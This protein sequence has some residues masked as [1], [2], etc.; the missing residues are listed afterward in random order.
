MS[1]GRYWVTRARRALLYPAPASRYPSPVMR[2]SA[3]EQDGPE[4]LPPLGD[5]SVFDSAEYTEP[6]KRLPLTV[7]EY[8][9][10]ALG[11]RG[12]IADDVQYAAVQR[13][14]RTYEQWVAYKARRNTAVKRLV[15][16]PPLPRG[17]YLWGPVGRGKSFLMDSFYLTVPLV[18][19]RRVHFHHFMRDVHREMETLKGRE[20]PLD[21]V[22]WRI[23]KRYRL[24]CFDEFH[25]NDIADAM[26]L[27]R[28]LQRTMDRGVV[29][30]MTSN[31]PPDGLYPDGLQRERF[32][33]TIALINERLDV[34]HIGGDVDYRRRALEQVKVYHA[35][36]GEAAEAAL[37]AA[38]RQVADVEEE[39][40]ELDVEGRTIPYRHRAGRRGLVR[41]RRPVRRPAVASRLSRPRA[42]LPHRHPVQRAAAL[43][44]AGK[45]GAPLHL[46]RRHLLRLQGEADRLGGGGA[47]GAVHGGR[48][49]QR[50]PAHREPADRDAVA[51]LPRRRAART[52]RSAA[53]ARRGAG[54]FLA[55]AV[56]SRVKEV[57]VDKFRVYRL[58][59][60]DRKVTAAFEQATVDE[61]DAGEVVVRVGYSC[62][63]YK[64]A[65]AATGAGRIIR[66]FPCIGGIDLSGTVVES[67]DPRF[68]KGDAVIGTSYDIGVAHD[69]GYA[70]YARLKAD[71]L[72][73]MPK[74]MSLFDAMALGTAGF[75]AA[76]A[77]V[78]ME[79]EGLKPGNGPVAVTGATGGVG[80]VAIDILAGLGHH[81]V[82]VTGKEQESAYLKDLGAKE[83][84]LRSSLDLAKIKPLDKAHVGGRGGQPRRR[85]ARL[86]RVHDEHR[87][88]ARCGRARR[89]H[90]AQDDGGAV[91]PARGEP[92][93]GG[94]GELPDAAT[95]PGL[96][97]AGGRPQ[98]EAPRGDDAHHPVR[99]PAEG[100]RRL[101]EGA[102]PRAGR[103]R[104]GRRLRR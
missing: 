34:V 102:D 12:Y 90:G 76:L 33:P 101:P 22:A 100:V 10:Q 11:R 86:A 35:P 40:H 78:R 43:G 61:L 18:R 15:V 26:I 39:F 80:S 4:P 87:R 92:A 73:P 16:R 36:L 75:T 60:A 30:C 71:W 3:Y 70:E 64:D 17:A 47:G 32:L 45:R 79:H 83:V 67:S 13:L 7:L 77:V 29:Y 66:R 51:R 53:G 37:L 81:V 84:M 41:L 72:V 14:Q 27:G 31:Y 56:K 50:V 38:F 9:Q 44:Q 8:Y 88:A 103:R 23:A 95:A 24:I 104:H 59:E 97:A 74:G 46:A 58:R 62:V 1:A 65:L 25:V 49:R 21:A 94:L 68:K 89:E 63:N 6:A 20:D 28:L 2:D 93:R 98:A 55:L 5:G 91:H 96:G 52:G 57:P 19:K 54:R 85:H 48:A 69:G 82:A 42:A 99:R